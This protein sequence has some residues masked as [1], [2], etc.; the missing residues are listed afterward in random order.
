MESLQ[1]GGNPNQRLHY[2]KSRRL[3]KIGDGNSVFNAG[4]PYAGRKTCFLCR[5]QTRELPSRVGL[6]VDT[7]DDQQHVGTSFDDDA[8]NEV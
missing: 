2:G 5:L 4:V 6:L 8:K 1:R 7:H 3:N